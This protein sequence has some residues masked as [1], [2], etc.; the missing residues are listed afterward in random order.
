MLD[1]AGALPPTAPM[2]L[3]V[4]DE[5]VL[6]VPRDEA[7]AV[8]ALVRNRMEEAAS[9]RVPLKVDLGVGDD[10]IAAKG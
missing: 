6:E 2:I 9:L 8:S 5:L 4:H 10:W 3:T 1:L 7:E